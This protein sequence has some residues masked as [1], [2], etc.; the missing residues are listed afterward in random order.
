MHASHIF[1]C[2]LIP[3]GLL[4]INLRLG[5]PVP[6]TMPLVFATVGIAF[7]WLR[8]AIM[9]SRS[10][11]LVLL[12]ATYGYLG[13]LGFAPIDGLRVL[14]AAAVLFFAL[15]LCAERNMV[16]RACELSIYVLTVF[17]VGSFIAP[18]PMRTLYEV[19]GLRSV[20]LYGGGGVAILFQEP[21]YLASAVFTMWA[22]AKSGRQEV[23]L[24]FAPVDVCSIAILLLSGSASAALYGLVGA[25]ILVRN[26]WLPI[27]VFSLCL[28]FAAVSSALFED[29]RIGGFVNAAA[30]VAE[31]S[32]LED[33]VLGFSLLDP[34]AAYRLSM[35]FV[36]V[37]A[38]LR[39]PLGH[40]Q[41]EMS[42]DTAYVES[43]DEYG[44]LSSNELVDAFFGNL[45]ANSVPF[46][47]LYFGGIPLFAAMMIVVAIAVWRLWRSRR[48]DVNYLLV[49]AALGSGCL[50][51]SLMTS[52]F[53][54]LA[55]AFGLTAN[56]GPVR[57][58]AGRSAQ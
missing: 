26:R 45:Q 29:S 20:D 5:L 33:A 14:T 1:A 21:S 23:R 12:I 10:M 50:I 39:E 49:I 44:V 40:L 41:L 7:L 37:S 55:L 51:Q 43:V 31:H 25:A 42:R 56:T 11:L 35:A 54:Y 47:L 52:P 53:L 2:V 8:R 6:E 24:R 30:S 48:H 9:L 32:T 4:S 16:T 19:L 46:Q 57:A 28:A 18:G 3:F 34:S 17:R 38:G 15:Q 58:V 36:A 27:A 13:I 22:I